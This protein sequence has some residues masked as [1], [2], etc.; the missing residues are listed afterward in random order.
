MKTA[1]TAK[2]KV[3]KKGELFPPKRIREEAGI[4]IGDEV[5]YHAREGTIEVVKIQRLN[6]AFRGKKFTSISTKKFEAMTS[7]IFS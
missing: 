4:A 7:E 6:E 3:G 2:G 1:T 5:V